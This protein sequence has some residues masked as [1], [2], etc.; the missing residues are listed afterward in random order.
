[1]KLTGLSYSDGR[2]ISFGTQDR[3]S[4]W[5]NLIEKSPSLDL[6]QHNRS[7]NTLLHQI[8][9]SAGISE[10][11]KSEMVEF[12]ASKGADLN[13]HSRDGLPPIELALRLSVQ[14]PELVDTL[15]DNGAKLSLMNV[16]RFSLTSLERGV[17]SH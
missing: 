10:T 9:L 4:V 8:I 12:L 1:M 7:G 15:R 17:K 11:E 14:Q 2:S 13:T 5:N 6:N 16:F 3:I